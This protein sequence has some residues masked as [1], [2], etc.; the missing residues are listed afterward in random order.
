MAKRERKFDVMS[1]K[2]RELKN[3]KEK[4]KVWR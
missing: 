2:R 3:G 4:Q 1:Y